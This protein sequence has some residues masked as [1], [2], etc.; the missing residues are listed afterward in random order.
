[1]K[2]IYISFRILL[3]I[4]FIFSGFVKLVDPWGAEIKFTE[5]LEAMGLDIFRALAFY[6]ANLLSILELFTGY[7]LVF[8]LRMRW[9][10]FFAF[11]LMLV[12]TPLTLWLAITG[13]VSDCGCFGDAVKLTDWETFW[14]NIA[15][16][17]P[18]LTVLFLW[19]KYRSTVLQK[20]QRLLSIIGFLFSFGVCYYS[21]NHL[22][23]LDFRPYALGENI[24]KGM[25]IPKDA[26]IDEYATT[27]IY[28]KDGVT[29]EFTE[30]N[31]PWQDTTW[32]FVDTKQKLIKKG[33]TPPITDFFI[34]DAKHE[35]ITTKVLENE[36]CLLI[37]SYKMEKTNFIQDYKDLGLEALVK[38]C[39]LTG[40]KSYIL[41]S[42]SMQQIENM[43]AFLRPSIPFIT[44]DDK[45]LEAMIRANPGILLLSHGTIQGKWNINDI[46]TNFKTIEEAYNIPPEKLQ[47]ARKSK[48]LYTTLLLFLSLT[49]ITLTI[50]KINKNEKKNRSGKL[51]NE[52]KL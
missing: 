11:L 38:E 19:K 3:G 36:K 2:Y 47:E 32:H 29:K 40:I 16:L 20:K 23:I 45:V 37:V 9:A 31:Y 49:I 4:V 17:I 10:S 25:K 30:D 28:K 42:S 26:P 43:R 50:L 1:M 41:T 52:P 24:E 6:L 15:L 48:E 5:Y 44:A 18:T 27:L 35:D 13:K 33:Y 34:V 39:S 7:L 46:P 21:Y 22:P 8:H 14:K 12:F 51:E